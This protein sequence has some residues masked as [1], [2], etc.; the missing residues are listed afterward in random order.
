MLEGFIRP[1]QKRSAFAEDFDNGE[2]TGQVPEQAMRLFGLFGR[3]LTPEL[4]KK[5]YRAL[6]KQYH[7][8]L[9]PGGLERSK[10]VNTAY[11]VL[12]ASLS[13]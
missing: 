5:R 7:P 12:L 9:N 11:T 13:V 10:Q 6:M 4:L 1:R 8:D 2:T 3:A